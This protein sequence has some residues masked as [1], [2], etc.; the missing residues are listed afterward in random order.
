MTDSLADQLKLVREWIRTSAAGRGEVSDP[1]RDAV[2]WVLR[3]ATY[4]APEEWN[5]HM[6]RWHS[7]L[8]DVFQATQQPVGTLITKH[9]PECGE[10]RHEPGSLS[11]ACTATVADLVASGDIPTPPD[12]ARERLLA[13]MADGGVS[14]AFRNGVSEGAL[15][16]LEAAKKA[17]RQGGSFYRDEGGEKAADFID[18][19]IDDVKRA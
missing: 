5:V 8:A 3:D 18:A 9:C 17:V 1:L 7:K 14:A 4:K 16:A 15:L 6:R 12:R 11:A 2:E 10:A 13:G 19:L